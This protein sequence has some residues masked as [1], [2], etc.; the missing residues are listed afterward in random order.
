VT[1][2]RKTFYATLSFIVRVGH[3]YV[4]FIV[5]EIQVIRTMCWFTLDLS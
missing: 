1:L 3:E 2:V 4:T 5:I